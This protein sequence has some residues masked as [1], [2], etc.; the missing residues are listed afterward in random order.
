MFQSWFVYGVCSYKKGVYTNT[1]RHPHPER[2]TQIPTERQTSTETHIPTQTQVPSRTEIQT[3]TLTQQNIPTNLY[4]HTEM[5]SHSQTQAHRETRQRHTAHT[6]PQTQTHSSPRD[7]THR[8]RLSTDNHTQAQTL[9]PCA[10][11]KWFDLFNLS[12]PAIGRRMER[13]GRGRGREQFIWKICP[14]G[15]SQ[16]RVNILAKSAPPLREWKK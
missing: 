10:C 13:N 16:A 5:L 14:F 1:D 2:H 11:V 15:W 12:Q 6:E 3:D 8:E 9:C 7:S 4:R